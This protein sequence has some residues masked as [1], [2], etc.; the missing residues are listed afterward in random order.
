MLR[1]C[2]ISLSERSTLSIFLNDS[3]K[4]INGNS[5]SNLSLHGVW[6]STIECFDSKMLFDPF[7]EDPDLPTVFEKQCNGQGW[8]NKVVGQEDES[9]IGF[10]VEI[11]DS[12]QR[13]GVELRAFG[14]LEDNR[15]IA[16]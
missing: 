12:P 6:R 9:T 2:R 1:I 8:K 7:E 13:I 5:D 11:T 14:S 15:L 4:H 16:S 10:G 3:Y